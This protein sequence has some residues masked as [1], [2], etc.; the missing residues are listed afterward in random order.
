MSDWTTINPNQL[1][2]NVF[3]SAVKGASGALT[4][5]LS[6][7]ASDLS[8]PSQLSLPSAPNAAEAVVKAI[9]DTLSKIL[10]GGRIHV[11]TVP[12][13][14]TYP[15]PKQSA[16]PPTLGDLQDA[17]NVALGPVDT[18]TADAYATLLAK[19][20]GN[21][22]FYNA[23]AESLMDPLDPHRPQYDNTH[24]AVAMAV[25]LVG[26]SRYT[27][28]S[29]AASMLDQLTRPKGGNG[30]AARTVPIPQNLTAK[31]VAASVAPGTGIEVSWDPP[32]ATY[33]SPYFP[34]VSNV[35]AKYA[36]IRTTD[37]SAMSARS[38]LNFFSTQS[39]TE[40]LTSGNATVVSVGDGK[41]STF[42]DTT[43]KLDAGTPVYYCVAWQCTCT[44]NGA[45]STLPFD[46]VSN[47]AKILVQP[48]AP[49]QTGTSPD[50]VAMGAAI[51]VFPAL[52]SAAKSL[53]AQAQTALT[54]SASSSSRLGNALK[55]AEGSA[56]RL[57]ARATEL[58]HDVESLATS[59]SRPIPSLY[60]T[61]MSSAKGGNVFLMSELARRLQDTSDASRPPFD[62]G[63][64]VCG[65]CFV[66][67]APRLADLANVLTFFN[68]LFGPANAANPLM[69]LL[70][71]IDTAVTQAET[72]VFQP[73]MTPYPTGTTGIDPLTGQP[74][75]VSTP[76]IAEDGTPTTTDSADNPNAG[77]TN[78][79]PTSELC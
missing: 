30:L 9:L 75:V 27:A 28:A 65:V 7:I 59:L 42:L 52:A 3:V 58:L 26:A 53:I 47:V 23:F 61:Q 29:S 39:L 31:V 44:E 17:L 60:V 18:T 54:P 33:T 41:S 66:A 64:Y 73:N 8:L 74:P 67:G 32:S 76:V 63:E 46:R 72:V 56:T 77:F 57:S 6:S 34:G 45:S 13:A 40:G 15:A 55:I 38:V 1:L 48:P 35:I 68:A 36:I 11:L 69:G 50:W 22:G 62:N 14:K 16:L 10:I 24:D 78:V 51:Q 20:G 2:P 49:P 19:T 70:A 79:V 71:A 5:L 12:F 21:A 43:V 37:S 4:G 25:L